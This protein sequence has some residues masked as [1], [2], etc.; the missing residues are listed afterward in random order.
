[1]SQTDI[2]FFYSAFGK[3]QIKDRLFEKEESKY[4]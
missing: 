3:L 4:R 2:F 1:M